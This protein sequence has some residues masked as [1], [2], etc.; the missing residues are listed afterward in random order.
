MA[1]ILNHLHHG[2]IT[3]TTAKQLLSLVFNGDER[4]VATI[5][6]EESLGLRH[7]SREE[8]L[9]MAQ[10]LIDNNQ[11]KVQQIREKKQ[12]GK[13]KWFVG[14]MMRQGEGRVDVRRAE[15]VLKEIIGLD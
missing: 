10:D 8:Y 6:E 15:A 12:L 4:E 5:I 9:A 14:Q 1:S 3:G 7:L 2:Q 13:F 11:D